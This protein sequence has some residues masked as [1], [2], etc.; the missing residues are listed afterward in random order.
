MANF[1]NIAV[2]KPGSGYSL[3]FELTYPENATEL[4][5]AMGATFSVAD[6]SL[7]LVLPTLEGPLTAFVPFNFGPLIIWDDDLDAPIDP[8]ALSDQTMVG[9]L[10]VVKGKGT[11]K[12]KGSNSRFSVS[13]EDIANFTAKQL[14][15]NNKPGV[16]IRF[17]VEC[18][19]NPAGWKLS[20]TQQKG[21]GVVLLP[22]K[23]VM[24][25]VPISKNFSMVVARG[26]IKKLKDREEEFELAVQ[27]YLLKKV[28]KAYYTDVELALG[29]KMARV[30]FVVMG[31]NQQLL[32]AQFA[33][34]KLMKKFVLKV[35]LKDAG[36]Y[37]FQY[38][39]VDGKYRKEC[40]R[41]RLLMQM[42]QIAM[43]IQNH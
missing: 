4:I 28:G 5:T 36:M 7:S 39:Y 1:E 25:D 19:I 20:E 18:S 33:I 38:L 12:F 32:N 17:E 26:N 34:C 16:D 31:S 3:M 30:N 27:T 15:L 29:K 40:N 35:K 13:G 43:D 37:K 11:P 9:Q 23:I 22:K 8:A 2:S 6:K 21:D 10:S 14:R 24:P 42:N 41:G